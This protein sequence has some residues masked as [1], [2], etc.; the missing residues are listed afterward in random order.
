MLNDNYIYGESEVTDCPEDGSYCKVFKKSGFLMS[1]MSEGG[2]P[3]MASMTSTLPM[4]K[5]LNTGSWG[6]MQR[7]YRNKFFNFVSQ[8]A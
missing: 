6:G 7:N 2:K 3:L 8:T 5:I 4:Y 1:G